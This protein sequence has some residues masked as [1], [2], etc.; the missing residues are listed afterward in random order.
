MQYGVL[1]TLAIEEHFYLLWPALV[2]RLSRRG[3]SATATAI[4]LLC[5]ILRWMYVL[6]GW[7]MGDYTW[8]Y[9]DGLALGAVLAALIR[10]PWG[11]R[12]GTWRLTAALG[13]ASLLL[14]GGGFRYG[15]FLASRPTGLVLRHT[16]LNIFFAALISLALLVG[17]SPW[18]ALVNRPVLRFFGA[19]SYGIYLIHMLV[20]ETVDHFVTLLRPD[21]AASSGH[22]GLMVLRFCFGTSLTVVVAY[23]SRW[24]FE[25]FFLKLKG[26]ATEAS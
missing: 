15:I 8:L 7:K 21:L 4:F 25:E 24:Y 13:A 26:P 20:F 16:A 5:A 22:F 2:R 11:S 12:S 6:L 3:V 18:K 17:T 10:G 14:F 9:A 23:L 1:W 19:I